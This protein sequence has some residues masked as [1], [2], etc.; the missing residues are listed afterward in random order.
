MRDAAI[1][2]KAGGAAAPEWRHAARDFLERYGLFVFCALL[3]SFGALVSD[4]FLSAKNIQDVLTQAAPLG[5][6]VVGQAFVLLVRGF[7]LSVASLMATVA[8]MRQEDV[9][10]RAL[11]T[12]SMRRVAVLRMASASA[13]FRM[14]P[15]LFGP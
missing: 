5:I 11:R 7:D 8:V 3:I 1:T 6:V 9:A 2:P 15:S 12:A 14:M 10:M 4:H 13:L